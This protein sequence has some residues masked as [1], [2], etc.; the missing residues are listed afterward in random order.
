MD[1]ILAVTDSGYEELYEL[2]RVEEGD[3]N[4]RVVRYSN[5]TAHSAQLDR[6]ISQN[7]KS[8]YGAG[9]YKPLMNRMPDVELRAGYNE[10]EGKYGEL[11][12]RW[13]PEATQDSKEPP[14]P[15]DPNAYESRDQGG[16]P[17]DRNDSAERSDTRW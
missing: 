1:G 10:K 2:E 7:S 16:A 11:K 17:K 6:L 13:T 14:T 9:E 5:S 12:L 8:F 4:G 15:N 3:L